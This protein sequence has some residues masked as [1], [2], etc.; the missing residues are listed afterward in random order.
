MYKITRELT[1]MDLFEKPSKLVGKYLTCGDSHWKIL[2]VSWLGEEVQGYACT[3]KNEFTGSITVAVIAF[4]Q[5]GVDCDAYVATPERFFLA[6][7]QQ[8]ERS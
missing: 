1:M 4:P 8:P 6:E 5:E 7:P 2:H 3:L